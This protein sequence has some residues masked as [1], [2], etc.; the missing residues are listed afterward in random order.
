MIAG[1]LLRKLWQSG[2]YE[3]IYPF[4]GDVRGDYIFWGHVHDLR[5]ID[6]NVIAARVT[7]DFELRDIK[8]A[9]PLWTYSYS[10]DE[11]VDGK[12]VA[13]VNAAIDRNVR[14]GL[15]GATVGLDEYFAG[16]P[17]MALTT[18]HQYPAC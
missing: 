4:R 2:R 9:T 1:V 6:G 3:H 13:A 11:P 10:H 18:A 16:N 12:D 7:F 17:A 8:T 5:E 15:S 14:S